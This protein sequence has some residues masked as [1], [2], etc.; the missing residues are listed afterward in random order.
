MLLT[1]IVF[2]HLGSTVYA[3]PQLPALQQLP[4]KNG[5]ENE[6]KCNTVILSPGSSG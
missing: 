3:Y 4:D 6:M 2:Y 5:S 1:L